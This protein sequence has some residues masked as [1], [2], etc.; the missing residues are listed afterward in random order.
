MDIRGALFDSS[1]S[2][3]EM[4][5]EA[6]G[7]NKKHFSEIIEITLED[8]YPVSMRAARVVQFSC[9]LHPYLIAP[10]LNEIIDKLTVFKVDGV[11]RSFLKLMSEDIDLKEFEQSGKLAC[12]CFDMLMNPKEAI[13]IRNYCLDIL[14]KIAEF[15]PD[16][17]Q[18]IAPILEIMIHEDSTGLKN[19]AGRLLEKHYRREVSGVR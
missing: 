19:K 18:E 13:A 6:I 10:Y 16:I 17:K 2:V 12:I 1:R 4:T 8:K 7:N 3:V 5:A 15:E 9:K 14:F 11:K